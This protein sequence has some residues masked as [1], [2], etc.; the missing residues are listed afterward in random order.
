[1]IVHNTSFFIPRSVSSGTWGVE[2]GWCC[3]VCA[4]CLSPSSLSPM[5]NIRSGAKLSPTAV[6]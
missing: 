5:V 4:M 3:Y 2:G 1:M 6:T